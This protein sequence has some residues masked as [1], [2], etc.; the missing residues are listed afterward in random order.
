MFLREHRCAM[1]Y[2]GEHV[3]DYR[4]QATVIN[5]RRLDV[6]GRGTRDSVTSRC[7]S[8]K[9]RYLVEAED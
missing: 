5:D 7:D 2:T 6:S 9:T 1:R 8:E 4:E 3:N